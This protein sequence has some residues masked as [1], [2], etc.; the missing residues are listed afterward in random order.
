MNALR[1]RRKR[2]QRKILLL[3]E[4]TDGPRYADLQRKI[5]DLNLKIRDAYQ[6][7]LDRKENVVIEKIKLNPKVFYSYAKSHSV[8]RSD[9]AM[10][11]DEEGSMLV[12]PQQIAAALQRHFSSVYSDP[13]SEAVE[14]P[15]I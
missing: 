11:R 12:Q 2:I 13:N 14:P 7:E 5:L 3:G 8:V 6:R 15:P 4:Q 1:R 10:L 9:I